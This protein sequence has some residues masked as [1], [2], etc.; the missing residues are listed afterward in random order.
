MFALYVLPRKGITEW[1]RA[2]LATLQ[3]QTMQIQTGGTVTGG[4]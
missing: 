1:N 3:W 2:D 4:H